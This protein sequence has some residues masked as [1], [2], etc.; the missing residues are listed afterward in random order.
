V[1]GYSLPRT[2]AG[3]SREQCSENSRR[4]KER[5]RNVSAYRRIGVSAYRV[6]A[7]VARL[8]CAPARPVWCVC[9]LPFVD[10]ALPLFLS[11]RLFP[12]VYVLWTCTAGRWED[13]RV[14]LPRDRPRDGPQSV[15]ERRDCPRNTRNENEKLNEAI[16]RRIRCQFFA[17]F[18]V[19][20]GP[21]L[22]S[23]R[24]YCT[25]D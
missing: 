17:S 9:K 14:T 6:W 12:F 10:F 20:R 8:G 7:R 21:Y 23:P 11:S 15:R 16:T 2:V 18:R 24:M 1:T 13:G 5:H 22:R 3:T 4:H 19:F 25:N